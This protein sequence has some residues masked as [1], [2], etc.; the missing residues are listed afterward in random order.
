LLEHAIARSSWNHYTTFDTDKK[1]QIDTVDKKFADELFGRAA[2]EILPTIA[3]GLVGLLLASLLAAVM[4]SSDAQM[5]VS[6]G[7]FTENIYKRFL[8][9]NKSQRHYLWIGRFRGWSS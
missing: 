8:V 3:P 7:L 2:Y 1:E 9:R 5:V 4:S 6:S